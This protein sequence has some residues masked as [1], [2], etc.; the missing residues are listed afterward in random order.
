MAAPLYQKF[1]FLLSIEFSLIILINTNICEDLIFGRMQQ[2]KNVAKFYIKIKILKNSTD[3]VNALD[4]LLAT[5]ITYTEL[6]KIK[7]KKFQKN[8]FFSGGNSI[9]E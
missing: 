4:F 6:E 7:K 2:T 1:F 5:L 3:R 9:S 8:V